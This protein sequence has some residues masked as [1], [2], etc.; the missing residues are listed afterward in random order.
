[1]TQTFNHGYALLIGVGAIAKY[2]DWSL[3]VT[4]KDMT[5]LRNLLTDPTR[6]AYP[7]RRRARATAP[8]PGRNPSGASWTDWLGSRPAPSRIR[9]PPSWSTTRATAG[10]TRRR[11]ATT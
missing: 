3:P 8:R 9:T 4:V 11:A 10:W 5:A 1:M 7:D 2:P 6:C